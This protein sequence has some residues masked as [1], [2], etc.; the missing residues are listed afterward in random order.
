MLSLD[1]RVVLAPGVSL[2]FS[3]ALVDSA[4]GARYPINEAAFALLARHGRL[5]DR[6][7]ELVARWGITPERTR[8]DVLTFGWELNRALLANIEPGHGRLR[9]AL[10]TGLLAL[11]LLPAG[12]LPP[13]IARR[14]VIDTRSVMRALS[15][16]AAALAPRGAA[17]ALV[18]A[19]VGLHAVAVVGAGH[20]AALG[21]VALGAATGAGLV[22]HEAAHAIALR[23]IPAAIVTRR[24]ATF[25]LHP[26][27]VGRRAVCVA[28]AGPA[29]P[30][31]GAAIVASVALG[32]GSVLLAFLACPLAGHGLGATVAGSD[33]RAACG[34]DC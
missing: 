5:G 32:R 22:A 13:A 4:R 7:V 28:L 2:D 17:V 9:R 18:V 15:T 20:A 27:L 26:P 33:G 10:A 6:A 30:A 11:R 19:L 3:G 25:V 1:D 29:A 14:R 12:A 31:A 21:A 16:T 8:A 34:L 24:L 23:G